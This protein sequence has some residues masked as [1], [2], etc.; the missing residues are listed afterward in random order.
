MT[1]S[2]KHIEQLKAAGKIRGYEF[3]K[4]LGELKAPGRIVSKYFKKRSKEKDW[5]AS[6]LLTWCNE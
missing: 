2:I 3:P 6:N 4:K 1:W 5:I